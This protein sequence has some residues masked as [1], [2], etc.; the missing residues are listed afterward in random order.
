M[1]IISYVL[2]L[3]LSCIIATDFISVLSQLD[4][5]KMAQLGPP[6][7]WLKC[8]RKGDLV[9]GIFLP[10]K[11]PLSAQ[12]ND[13]VPEEHRFTPNMVLQNEYSEKTIGLWIDLTNTTR[14]YSKDEIERYGV[15]YKKIN[16]KG[17]GECPSQQTVNEFVNLCQEH[18]EL[19]PDSIIAV[20]CTHGF[21][22]TGFL[23]CSYL[24]VVNDWSIDAA[25]SEFAR[26]RPPGI[27]KQDY[28]DEIFKRFDEVDSTPIAP[29]LPLWSG[30]EDEDTGET[31]GSVKV[32]AYATGIPS[33]TQVTDHE[34]IH[35]IQ[36]FCG[37]ICQYDGKTFPGA[38][39]VSM[40]RSNINLL[41]QELYKVSWKADGTRY[42]MLIE[43]E[44][45]VFM[46]DR[47]NN[48]FSVP[49]LS[50][51]LP[52]LSASPKQTLVDGELVLDRLNGVIYPRYLIYD[53]MAINGTSV[54]NLSYYDRERII[55]KEIIDPRNLALQRGKLD[56]SREPF[57]VR[58][59]DFY[60]I[61]CVEKLLGPKF[62]E[63]V[64]HETDGVVF[65]PVNDP[66][67]G[68]TS[69]KLLKWKPP[70]LNSV[71]FL[72][73]VKKDTRPGSLG[74]LIGHLMVTGLHAPF[75][76]IKMTKD[77][78]K[79]DGKIIECTVV[80]GAWKFLRERTDKDSPNSYQTAQAVKESI[81]FPVTQ[82]DL[83]KFVKEHSYRPSLM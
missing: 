34:T 62:L 68:G 69:P 21:N 15:V 18:L 46:I 77:L 2:L 83:L 42:M 33:S 81:R 26:A 61:S 75:D 49:G 56:K 51:F 79:Y 23:I 45:D 38:Q 30:V 25:A 60:D 32:A 74:T 50:F 57:G 65:Q 52:D 36:Q 66:Y 64:L 12:Y 53:V 10:F 1:S 67:R 44:N 73:H 72:L 39:P 78:M 70:E 16:C 24:V 76:Y 31:S 71:D 54:V 58:R 28:L 47:K 80:D 43:N 14:F 59:K 20:H 35:R 82:S 40:D 7:R 13:S 8:P 27:Y 11:T 37:N 5:F 4:C 55:Q 6:A 48:I 29:P 9:A 3:N 19:N 63:A 22:R 41:A 17:F